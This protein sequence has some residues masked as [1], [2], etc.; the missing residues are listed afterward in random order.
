MMKISWEKW[1]FAAPLTCTLLFP[2]AVLADEAH[3]LGQ[4]RCRL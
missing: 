1:L 4:R 3:I 2:M